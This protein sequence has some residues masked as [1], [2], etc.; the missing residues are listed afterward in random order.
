MFE[1]AMRLFC[2]QELLCRELD[3]KEG[4]AACLG[5]QAAIFVA[6]GEP[7][8]AMKL[9]K[10][11]EQLCR[12]FSIKDGLQASLGNQALILQILG[13]ARVALQL[14]KEEERLCRE[15]GNPDALAKSL[16]VQAMLLSEEMGR[17]REAVP[18]AEEAYRIATSHG[19]TGLARQVKPVLD[20]VRSKAK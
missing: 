20:M 5:N 17:P 14:H 4:L 15:I 9:L 12:Q 19:L 6:C 16:A 1:E 7:K 18:L 2:E 10:E 8:T 11:Q 13:E 3:S